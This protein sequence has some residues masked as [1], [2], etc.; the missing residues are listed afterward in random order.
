MIKIKSLNCNKKLNNNIPRNSS[1]KF[2]FACLIKYRKKTKKSKIKSLF[3][4]S[5]I[6]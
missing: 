4:K 5:I 3:M 2:N 1:K 6:N